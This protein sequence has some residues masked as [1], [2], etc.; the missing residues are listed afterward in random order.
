MDSSR[1]HMIPLVLEH[2]FRARSFKPLPFYYLGFSPPMAVAFSAILLFRL[3]V[4]FLKLHLC[5][6]HP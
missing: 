1:V 3:V 2:F 5:L 6:S 4:Y